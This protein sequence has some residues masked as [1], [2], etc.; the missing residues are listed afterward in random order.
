M[1]DLRPHAERNYICDSKLDKVPLRVVED[2]R[3]VFHWQSNDSPCGE[4]TNR[5]V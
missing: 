1:C 3:I 2:N 4:K 5:N